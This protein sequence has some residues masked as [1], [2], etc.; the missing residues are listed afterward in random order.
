LA[1]VGVREE[2]ISIEHG[3]LVVIAGDV[4]QQAVELA[5]LF[6]GAILLR[7]RRHDLAEDDW[8]FGMVRREAV[9]EEIRV[10]G[11][12]RRRHLLADIVRADEEDDA[13]GVELA[14]RIGEILFHF[15]PSHATTA[16]LQLNRN[17]V[18][19]C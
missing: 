9:E 7:R 15:S 14:I 13:A 4:G 1:C 16:L 11:Y 6:G 18:K 12:V 17:G 8:H 10:A 19:H 2:R 3:H 5:D